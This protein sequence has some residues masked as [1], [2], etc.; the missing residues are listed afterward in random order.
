MKL[1]NTVKLKVLPLL[2]ASLFSGCLS[3]TA[4]QTIEE[5]N[6]MFEKVVT[7]EQLVSKD[8]HGVITLDTVAPP[9]PKLP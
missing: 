6:R 3:E 1:A 7:L 4:K 9:I 8:S 2:I 5:Y